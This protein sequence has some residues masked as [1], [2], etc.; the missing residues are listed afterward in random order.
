VTGGLRVAR[1][2][3]QLLVEDLGRPG[4]AHVGVPPSGALDPRALALANRL[5]GNPESAAGLEILLGGCELLAGRS[6]R[7]ALTGAQLP[8]SVDSVPKPW[9]TAVSV[10]AGRRIQVGTSTVGLRSWLAVAGGLVPPTTLGSR[11]TDTLTGLGPPPVRSGDVLPVGVMPGD[12][13]HG[14]A[15]PEA[16]DAP[17]PARLRVRLGPRDDELTDEALARFLAGEYAVSA[18]SDRVGVRLEPV[19][20][21]RLERR[22]AGELESEAV[23]TGAVQ[24]PS[25]GQPLIFLADHPVTGGYPVVAV[26]DGPDLSRCAQLR[27]G[28]RV[29]FVTP[30]ARR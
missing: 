16:P 14:E 3:P 28:A 20:G 6:L 21:R 7:I 4:W 22:H 1:S 27:P 15:V 23:V 5:V 11:S 9:G 26:V 13:G 24:V 25:G 19:D 18:D 2:A 17:G 29:S 30:P 10:G 12:A 8:L